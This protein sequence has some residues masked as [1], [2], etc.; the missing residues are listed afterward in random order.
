M[1]LNNFRRRLEFRKTILKVADRI[2]NDQLKKIKFIYGTRGTPGSQ[3]S[4]RNETLDIFSDLI[5]S[6]FIEDNKEL[7]EMLQSCL[8]EVGR[9]DLA[10]VIS[11]YI[12]SKKDQDAFTFH[13]PFPTQE[14]SRYSRS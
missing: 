6:S 13:G 7:L 14:R 1:D 10:E 12:E 11:N 2:S 4:S 3:D 8:N 5:A 9:A